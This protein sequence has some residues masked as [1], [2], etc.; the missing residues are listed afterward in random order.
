MKLRLTK[1]SGLSI[2][3][4]FAVLVTVSFVTYSEI[5]EKTLYGKHTDKGWQRQEHV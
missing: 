1:L 2:G 5:G 4:A 3:I